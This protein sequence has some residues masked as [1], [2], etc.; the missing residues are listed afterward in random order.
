M[1]LAFVIRFLCWLVF[2]SIFFVFTFQIWDRW[3]HHDETWKRNLDYLERHCNKDANLDIHTNLA[4]ECR[5]VQQWMHTWPVIHACKDVI[6]SK[7][8]FGTTIESW[9]VRCVLVVLL[10]VLVRF[11]WFGMNQYLK[12]SARDSLPMHI[13][14]EEYG[15]KHKF[16]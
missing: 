14:L 2:S 15:M 10:F 1:T 12:Y 11:A 8:L 6:E 16:N 7:V 3:T 4:I 9:Q 5:N 13:Q